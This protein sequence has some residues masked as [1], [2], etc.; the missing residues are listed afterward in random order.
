MAWIVALAL[1]YLLGSVPWGLVLT[2]AAGH[3]DIRAIGSGN[4]GATN[5]LRTGN[6]ALA[7]ATLALDA[8]KGAAALLIAEAVWGEWAGLAAG[9][10]A[11]LGHAFPVWLRFRGGKGVATGGGVLLVAS[12]WMGLAAAAAWLATAAATRMSSAGSLAACAAAPLVALLAGRTDLALFAAGIAA[13]VVLRHRG[14][15][16]RLLAGTEPRIGRKT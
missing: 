15:I 11:M 1:G 16:A 14:N 9:F 10:G 13:L 7:A 8:L 3:G 12:W 4:I 5:V 6:K 2:R